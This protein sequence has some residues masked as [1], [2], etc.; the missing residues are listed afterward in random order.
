MTDETTANETAT[1]QD[2]NNDGVSAEHASTGGGSK[3][4][5]I[6]SI[7][8]GVFIVAGIAWLLMYIFVFSKRVA[9]EDA[10]VQ[11]KQ[12]VVSS[13]IP[14]TVVS[15]SGDNTARVEAGQTIVSLDKTDAEVGLAHARSALA[16]A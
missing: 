12:V 14:G 11:G 10:Y 6:L 15:V 16:G 1:S 2:R 9:T 13:Q 8:A 3:R 5:L 7:I 4:K